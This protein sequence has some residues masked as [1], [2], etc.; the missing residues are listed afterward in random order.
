M[1]KSNQFLTLCL[2]A[3]A[4]RIRPRPEQ[5]FFMHK[6]ISSVHRFLSFFVWL[7]VAAA[8]AE[9]QPLLLPQPQTE[10]GRPLMQVLLDRKT[11]REFGTNSL[12]L[13]TLANLLWAGFGTNRV[14]GHRTAPSTMNARSIELYVALAGGTYVYEPDAHRLRPVAAGDLRAQTGGQDFV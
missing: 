7:P 11:T 12:P 4:I 13:Q 10:I 9:L 3:G 8:A 6:G 14:D 5:P 2:W 1:A